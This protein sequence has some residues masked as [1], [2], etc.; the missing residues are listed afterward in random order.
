M[1]T[2]IIDLENTISNSSD[3][4]WLLKY[5]G[6]SP[7]IQEMYDKQF[8]EAFMDDYL[9]MNVKLFMDT[10]FLNNNI[11]I[12]TAKLEK[13]RNLVVSWLEHYGVKYDS[14]IMKQN[15]EESDIIF[16]RKYAALNAGDINFALDDV[17][18]N[19]AM[20]GEYGIPCLRIEQK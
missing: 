9:N 13:Y 2:V 17:G 14:L 15:E 4:M 1:M 19:C 6:S 11:I 3:R 7:V 10:L 5:G 12:L 20:F 8:Q 16:K 18:A